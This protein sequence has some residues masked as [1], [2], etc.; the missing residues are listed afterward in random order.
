MSVT[1][2]P[3]PNPTTGEEHEHPAHP[4]DW[5]YVKVAVILAVLTGV[6]VFTYFESVLDW[7]R[8]LMPVLIILMGVKFYLI[9]TYFMHLKF[10]SRVLQFAFLTGIVLALGVYIVMLITFEF[11]RT[12]A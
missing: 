8:V 12:W 2:T 1:E 7:G 4:S 6:E 10:D 3:T 11:F 9:A 5:V